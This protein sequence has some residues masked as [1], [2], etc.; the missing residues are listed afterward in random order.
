M[1]ANSSRTLHL[2]GLL[3][4]SELLATPLAERGENPHE[5]ANIHYPDIP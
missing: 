2:I 5:H 3:K 1:Q 4:R